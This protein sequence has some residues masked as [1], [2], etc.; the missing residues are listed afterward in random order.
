MRENLEKNEENLNVDGQIE[1]DSLINLAS[2]MVNL[3]ENNA[4]PTAENNENPNFDQTDVEIN[5][6]MVDKKLL[7]KIKQLNLT[8]LESLIKSADFG[9]DTYII[10][11]STKNL[12]DSD[13][14]L[15]CTLN[16]FYTMLNNGASA[17]ENRTP[18]FKQEKFKV[19]ELLTYEEFL[20]QAPV[21]G[22]QTY[23]QK[24]AQQNYLKDKYERL[25]KESNIKVKGEKENKSY[26]EF[27]NN[28]SA[29][30]FREDLENETVFMTTV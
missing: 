16:E 27:L 7:Q 21:V 6:N 12:K 19:K 23:K 11:S 9:T 24:K 1:I 10:P 20:K 3:S 18:F 4:D 8:E 15:F 26:L 28:Y 29:S 5:G 2:D 30:R 17:A 25:F 13:F 14:P 22:K